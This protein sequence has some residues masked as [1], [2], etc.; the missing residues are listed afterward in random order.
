M[1]RLTVRQFASIKRI[2]QNVNPL[3]VKKNKI[4]EKIEALQI[5]KEC[6]QNEINGHEAGVQALTDGYVSEQLVKKVVETTDKVDK[7][8]NLIKV[9]KYLPTD[10]VIYNEEENCYYINENVTEEVETTDKVVK[11]AD[12][13]I[14]NI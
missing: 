11:D 3:V 1:K 14:D 10:S 4:E 7:D 12:N 2:A 13:N 5:E 9:T 6:L 8:G